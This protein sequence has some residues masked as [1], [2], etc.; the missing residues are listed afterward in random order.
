M[1]TFVS[2]TTTV[3][4]IF[5]KLTIILLFSPFHSDDVSCALLPEVTAQFF[6]SRLKH[7]L[8]C[9]A[10]GGRLGCVHA[11]TLRRSCY[12]RPHNFYVRYGS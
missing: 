10:R 7:W 12:S 6:H 3:A 1:P 8:R 2:V 4:C 11:R 9:A 5:H